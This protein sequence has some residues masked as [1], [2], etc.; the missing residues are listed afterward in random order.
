M[1]QRTKHRKPKKMTRTKLPTKTIRTSTKNHNKP[2]GELSDSDVWFCQEYVATENAV[3]SYMKTHPG[4]GYNTAGVEGSKLLKNPKIQVLVGKL[5]DERNKRLEIT[6]DKVLAVFAR[7]AFYDPAELYQADGKTLKPITQLPPDLAA[8]ITAI[9]VDEN[10][11]L[12]TKETRTFTKKIK[13]ADSTANAVH[14][15]KYLNLTPE[16]IIFPDKEGNPQNIN[17][18]ILNLT[19][20]EIE[21]EF[22][23]FS[24]IRKA[25]TGRDED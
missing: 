9:E 15:A 20:E 24:K 22:L 11:N 7:R 12:K 16:R 13:L 18:S 17:N 5:R 21:K 8:C 6:A 14:L 23:R 19:D 3:R 2:I 25:I 4:V 10:Y 1:K